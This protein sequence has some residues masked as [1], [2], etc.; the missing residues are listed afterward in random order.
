MKE[1]LET[2]DCNLCGSSNKKILYKIKHFSL[3]FTMV[4]CK[5]CG[6]VY[7]DP[8]HN[9]DNLIKFYNES[10]YA[11]DADYSY[12]DERLNSKSNS[13]IYHKR[14]SVIEKYLKRNACRKKLINY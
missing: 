5:D 13:I 11:G 12:A 8:R 2:V 3:N 4:K 1:T 7:M 9:K 6:L 14:L 10:Y